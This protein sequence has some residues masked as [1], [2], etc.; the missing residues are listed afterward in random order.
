MTERKEDSRGEVVLYQASD[1]TV[2]LDVRLERESLW[3]SLNQMAALFDRDKSVI[4]RHLRN[5]FNDGELDREAVVAENAT[6]AVDGKAY[7]VEFFNLDAI[8]S[9]GYRVNSERGTQFRIWATRVLR[10]H[11]LQGY[12]V[13]ANRPRDLNQTVLLVAGVIDRKDLSGDEAKGRTTRG[14]PV[15]SA[16]SCRPSAR[17]ISTP[18]WRRR[19]LT[20][21]TSSSRITR[22]SMATN[23]LPRRCSSGFWSATGSSSSA[24]ESG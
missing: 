8:I 7:Q 5:V 24:R 23:V 14:W 17:R 10:D 4:S 12:S 19:P 15:P 16:R 2:S 18:A 20:C 3:L 11:V 21:S 22:S 13:N 9:V 1:G 6:T